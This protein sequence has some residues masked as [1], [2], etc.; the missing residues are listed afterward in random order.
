[1]SWKFDVSFCAARQFRRQRSIN[2]PSCF[3]A[4]FFA[5]AECKSSRIIP[6]G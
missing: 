1:M 3:A 2:A 6:R 5:A 4:D